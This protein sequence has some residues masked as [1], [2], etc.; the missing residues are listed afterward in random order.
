MKERGTTE[1]IERK[2]RRNG[3]SNTDASSDGSMKQYFGCVQSIIGL[4]TSTVHFEAPAAHQSSPAVLCK[5]TTRTSHFSVFRSIIIW[6]SFDA[7]GHYLTRLE[8][9]QMNQIQPASSTGPASE[10]SKVSLPLRFWRGFRYYQVNIVFIS[11]AAG[12]I[13]ADW[14]HTQKWKA[15]K[16]LESKK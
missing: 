13:Y 6:P 7:I 5:S 11:L 3:F 8:V 2:K 10:P 1:K 14:S 12:V 4:V 9:R 16:A 15:Q